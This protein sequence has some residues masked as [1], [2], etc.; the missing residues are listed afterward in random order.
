MLHELDCSIGEG[1][2]SVVRLSVALAAARNISIRLV[3]I[4]SKRSKPGLRA[5]HVE[6]IK[7]IQQLSGVFVSGCYVGSK[8]ISL[9]EGS[10]TKTKANVNISTAGS[11]GLVAQAV[12]YYCYPKKEIFTLSINGGATHG[13][14]AP[15]IDYL[16]H[17]THKLLLLTNKQIEVKVLKYGFYPKGGASCIIKFHKHNSLKAL[18][19]EERATLEKIKVFSICSTQLKNRNVAKRQFDSFVKNI[20]AN[21]NIEPKIKYA[22]TLCLGSA[23]TVVNYYS[24]GAA[25]GFFVTGEKNLSSEQVGKF[26][27]QKWNQFNASSASVD[28]HAADQLILPLALQS[29]ESIFST[30]DISQHTETNISL[31]QKFLDTKVEIRKLVGKYSIRIKP[32]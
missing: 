6:A 15:S 14:W 9:Q 13:K 22:N 27:A 23:L 19:L 4:R 10:E 12:L 3:N 24:N 25:A 26:C 1:G 21:V 16:Q 11:V 29:E 8:T 18:N 20:S 30:N 31:V 5:Q 7:A 28:S 17:V 32:S 2:G